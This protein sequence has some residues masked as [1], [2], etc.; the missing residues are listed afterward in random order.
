MKIQNEKIPRTLSFQAYGVKIGVS[1]EGEIYLPQ[2]RERLDAV[3][4]N[5][6]EFIDERSVEH[7]LEAAFDANGGFRIVK[8]GEILIAGKNKDDFI[9]SAISQIRLTIA[10]FARDTVFLHA[11][12]IGWKGRAVI[13]PASSFA[14]K[15][16]LVAELIKNGALYYSDEYAVLD[17][18]GLVYPYPKMLSVRGLTDDYKQTDLTAES[19]GA[20]TGDAPLPVGMILICRFDT[21]AADADFEPEILTSGQGMIEVLAHSISIRHN[22]KLVLK[23]LNKVSTRAIIAKSQRGEAKPF[24]AQLIKYLDRKFAAIPPEIY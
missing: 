7:L 5:G 10:E 2:I 6:Y 4:P 16:T 15:T 23:V 22:P 17:E 20:K 13:I 18:R 24:V 19:F 3:L 8:N 21:N 14:G 9:D 1:D 12:V 11:G